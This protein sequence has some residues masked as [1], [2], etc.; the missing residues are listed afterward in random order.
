M[1]G[2]RLLERERLLLMSSEDGTIRLQ[3]LVP[4]NPVRTPEPEE[5]STESSTLSGSNDESA[6]EAEKKA[7]DA[8]GDK[9]DKDEEDEEEE[10]KEEKDPKEKEEAKEEDDDEDDD[11]EDDSEGD[12]ITVVKEAS[13]TS[14]PRPRASLDWLNENANIKNIIHYWK[15]NIHDYSYGRWKWKP[16]ERKE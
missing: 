2:M 12:G 1:T 16:K 6:V 11:D 7:E 10:E 13:I 3:P 8:E 4:E 14:L 15:L 9:G 5:D